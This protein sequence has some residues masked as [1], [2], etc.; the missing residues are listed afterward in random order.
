LWP[1]HSPATGSP[2][3]PDTP[4][5]LQREASKLWLPWLLQHGD[6]TPPTSAELDPNRYLQW[7]AICCVPL[8]LSLPWPAPCSVYDPPVASTL[9]LVPREF[10]NHFLHLQPPFLSDPVR[11]LLSCLQVT[12]GAS[13]SPR[14]PQSEVPSRINGWN[15]RWSPQ[16]SPASLNPNTDLLLPTEVQHPF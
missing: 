1:V 5:W 6:H 13:A 4:P 8:C 7:E 11:D 15:P 16:P 9:W 14:T 2:H 10:S 12:P 3:P